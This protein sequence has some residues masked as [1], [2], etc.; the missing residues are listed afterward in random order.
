MIEGRFDRHES[1]KCA[2]WARSKEDAINLFAEAADGCDPDILQ[3]NRHVTAKRLSEHTGRK[4]TMRTYFRLP[5]TKRLPSL[6]EYLARLA[7]KK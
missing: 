1:I 7:R 6:E 2:L 3:S 5:R 4:V